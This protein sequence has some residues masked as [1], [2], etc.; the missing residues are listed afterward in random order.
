MTR[1][2]L[3]FQVCI[4]LIIAC[5]GTDDSTQMPSSPASSAEALVNDFQ[6]SVFVEVDDNERPSLRGDVTV[7]NVGSVSRNLAFSSR[8]WVLL[9]AYADGTLAWDQQDVSECDDIITEFDLLPGEQRKL[10]LEA[11]IADILGDDLDGGIYTITAYLEPFIQHASRV[12][13]VELNAGQHELSV[14]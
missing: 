2:I 12:T 4:V 9:R 6:Y 13:E 14:D 1:N 3:L 7:S 11:P 8:C 10:P 5:G